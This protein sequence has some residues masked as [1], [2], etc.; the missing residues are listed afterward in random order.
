VSDVSCYV[1]DSTMLPALSPAPSENLFPEILPVC[2][3]CMTCPHTRSRKHDMCTGHGTRCSTNH[4]QKLEF[5]INL[6]VQRIKYMSITLGEKSSL[7][8]S[9]PTMALY[10][11]SVPEVAIL[12]AVPALLKMPC[13]RILPG[14]AC[15][16][17]ATSVDQ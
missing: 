12:R 5:A 9:L 14:G 1:T 13:F 11:L 6:Q 3:T 8:F 17:C 10:F 15:G 2:A 4:K 7:C 16:A